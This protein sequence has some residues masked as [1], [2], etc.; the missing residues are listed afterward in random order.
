MSLPSS[1][2]SHK[3]NAQVFKYE[4]IITLCSI[5]I[6][7]CENDGSSGNLEHIL[8]TLYFLFHL[9]E[10]QNSGLLTLLTISA[11]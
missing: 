1:M 2:I 6:F 9:L 7:K 3:M 4:S 8:Q 10:C 5:L 11:E